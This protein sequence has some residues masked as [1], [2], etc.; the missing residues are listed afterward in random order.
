M[1]VQNAGMTAF[2]FLEGVTDSH[3]FSSLY[4]AFIKLFGLHGQA[5]AVARET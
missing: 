2:L 4:Q 5:A 1:G 3:V